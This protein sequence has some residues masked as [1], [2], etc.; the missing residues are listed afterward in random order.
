MKGG[1][2]GRSSM[3]WLAALVLILSGSSLA[4]CGKKRVAPPPAAVAPG[5]VLIPVPSAPTVT[6]AATPAVIDA[7]RSSTIKWQ[8]R[9][10]TTVQIDEG[11]GTVAVSGSRSVSPP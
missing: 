9:K 6:I 10:A 5:P 11:I 8:A 4:G 7:G 2:A 1:F 3:L